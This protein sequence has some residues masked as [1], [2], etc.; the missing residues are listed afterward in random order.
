MTRDSHKNLAAS[1]R[2]RLLDKAR[3]TG[4]PFNEM[5]SY[6]GM[7]RFLYRLSQST[8]ASSFVLKGA[9]LLHVW[10]G[11]AARSTSDIDLLGFGPNAP[12]AVAERVRECL[13]V[14]VEPDGIN[15]DADSVRAEPI[16]EGAD[17]QG[18]RVQIRGALGKMQLTLQVDVG[19]GDALEPE[20]VSIDYPILLDL[21]APKLLGY[22]RESLVAEK[23]EAMVKLG[24]ANSRMKDFGD[25][26]GLSLTT[27]FEGGRLQRAMEATLGKRGTIIEGALPLVLTPE[28]ALLPQ[29]ET[30]W[31][32]YLKKRRSGVKPPA[33][34]EEVLNS[35]RLFLLP[36]FVALQQ[37]AQF[38][39]HWLPGG[40]WQ[41]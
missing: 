18:V 28:F 36:P 7:E 32:S 17:Y 3:K 38:K 10:Q 23:F 21:P 24:A 40:P 13:M 27:P 19:F 15:F 4:R 6:Y 11:E 9:L 5:L 16:T 31:R 25:I 33:S 14:D 29:K 8:Y 2:Q 20:P 1:I 22:S 37:H 39:S 12:K 26:Y 35:I 34:L 30:Q 41:D